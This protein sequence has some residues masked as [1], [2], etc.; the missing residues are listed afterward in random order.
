MTEYFQQLG[1]AQLQV[2]RSLLGATAWQL[3]TD[4]VDVVDDDQGRWT[5]CWAMD[6]ALLDPSRKFWVVVESDCTGDTPADA[7]NL[8]KMDVY[9]ALGPKGVELSPEGDLIAASKV[10]V[11]GD[12]PIASITVLSYEES[13]EYDLVRYDGALI[14]ELANGRVWA[15][16]VDSSRMIGGMH[17]IVDPARIEGL[18]ATLSTRV[19]LRQ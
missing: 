8:H 6:V 14:F 11:P 12:A 16:V 18:R 15:L 5:S 10:A 7:I 2:L 9:S 13:A 19:V 4:S 17:V 1:D 3:W